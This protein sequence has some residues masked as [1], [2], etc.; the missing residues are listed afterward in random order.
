[1]GGQEERE[2]TH[3]QHRLNPAPTQQL[4]LFLPMIQRLHPESNVDRHAARS[5]NVIYMYQ[6]HFERNKIRKRQSSHERTFPTPS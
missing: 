5:A 2:R 3:L 4:C 6:H 1:M